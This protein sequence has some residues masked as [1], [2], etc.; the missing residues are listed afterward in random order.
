[1]KS[2][3]GNM[4]RKSGLSAFLLLSSAL[5][6]IPTAYAQDAPANQDAP[7]VVAANAPEAPVVMAANQGA[8]VAA[9]T[10]TEEIYVT[11]LKRE[12]RLQ[13]TP[14]AISVVDVNLLEERHI[15][16]L[17]D[18]ADGALPSLRMTTFESRQTALTIGIRG[19]VPGDANQ[20]AREQGV[21]IYLDG[22][23][24]GRQHG[25]NAAMLDLQQVE[26]L[27]GPQGT[28]FGR[29]TEG[30]AVS[31]ITR[32]PSGEFGYRATAGISNFNGYNTAIHLDLPKVY[33]F[34]VKLDGA[35][36]YHDAMTKNPM[37]GQTGWDFVDR[38]GFRVSTLWQPIDSVEV[39]YS[40]DVS[41]SKSS[42]LYTQLVNYNPLGLPVSSAFP[43]PAGTISPL[44]PN[45]FVH[46]NRQKVSDI[47]VPQQ[48]SIDQSSGHT[49]NITWDIMPNLM[50]RSI[51]AYRDV[52][53]DQF[54]NAPGPNR[55]PVF[56]PYAPEG[57]TSRN[58]SRYSL[59]DL[60]QF[61]RSQEFQLVGNLG[62]RFDFAL[63]VYYFNEKAWEEA[64]T[65]STLR[66]VG[67]NGEYIVLDPTAFPGSAPG[68][69][70]IDRGSVAWAE[71]TGVYLHTVYTPAILNDALHISLGGRYT[72]DEK[73]GTLY[74]VSNLDRNYNFDLKEDRFDPTVTLAFDVNPDVNVYATYATGYRAGGANSRS[75]TYT[76][77]ESE[78]VKSYEVGVKSMLFDRLR[79]NVAAFMMDRTNS[80]IEF[81]LVAPDPVSGS[82]RNTVA[83]VNAPGTTDLNG[84]EIEGNFSITEDLG[85]TFSYAYMDT[86][87]PPAQNPFPQT[88]ACPSCGAVQ[89][90]YIIYTPKHAVSGALDYIYPL[91]SGNLRAHLDGNYSTGTQSFEAFP[92]KTDDALIFNARLA[93]ANIDVGDGREMTISAWSRNIFDEAHIYR[94]SP[95]NRSGTNAIGDYANF[96]EP[97]TFGSEISF[98]F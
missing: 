28:L 14:I 43:R 19:I 93:L 47:G 26:V 18:L 58:F 72:S 16:S 5:Y 56:Q 29:N 67:S 23:Y 63:G 96:N 36:Q 31:M 82:N 79:L 53:A 6:A 77:F 32:R 22:V 48:A 66:W 1:M 7:V 3:K 46:P 52:A 21:G 25:L 35:L 64:A 8:L 75:L 55:P 90:V 20:P 13:A 97:R 59:S 11:A 92:L 80:Q 17:L 62:E 73:N 95:E 76:P 24:L 54:D 44:P 81:S 12:T 98:N 60:G 33:N 10:T 9:N 42:P 69:R 51:T 15:Q 88:A 86:H 39:L 74:K 94:R 84:L 85:L 78:E 61:Q 70:S 38:N 34:S 49:V 45:V 30:G 68:A 89:P 41:K 71:S 37:A 87:V 91:G 27:R 65:P 83:T 50:L 57:N 2:M 4:R 40:Y